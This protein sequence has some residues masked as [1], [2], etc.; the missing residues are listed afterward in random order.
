[1]QPDFSFPFSSSSRG[2]NGS[3]KFCTELSHRSLHSTGWMERWCVICEIF[4][5]FIVQAPD[6]WCLGSL[7]LQ[8]DLW[9][10]SRWW[11]WTN[12]PS[13]LQMGN[14]RRAFYPLSFCSLCA[15]KPQAPQKRNLR[16][17]LSFSA[18][19]TTTVAWMPFKQLHMSLGGNADRF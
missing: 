6:Y 10:S 16:W 3:K 14:H 18:S 15:E 1:M 11:I 4:Q 8:W 7:F 9:C 5:S 19:T 12:F 17:K 13:N 2:K